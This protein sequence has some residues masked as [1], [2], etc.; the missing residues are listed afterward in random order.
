MKLNRSRKTLYPRALRLLTGVVVILAVLAFTGCTAKP[1]KEDKKGVQLQSIHTN[2][3]TPPSMIGDAV[4]A[5]KAHNGQRYVS[6]REF[7]DIMQY[8][9]DWDERMQTMRIGENDVMFEIRSNSRE[10]RKDGRPVLLSHPAVTI[11]GETFIPADAVGALFDDVMQYKM[12]KEKLL[13]HP[14]GPQGAAN[15]D[16]LPDFADDPGDPARSAAAS[17]E[18]VAPVAPASYDAAAMP[19][20]ELAQ[21]PAIDMDELIR[22]AKQYLGVPYKFGANP[23]SASNKWFD[24]SSYTRHVFAEFGVDLPRLSRS[25]AQEGT[26]VSRT[27]L[28]KGDLLF[29]YLPGRYKSNDI[30]GHVGIYMGNGQM[31]HSSNQPDD[32]VQITSINKEFWKETYLKARRV[33]SSK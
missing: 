21:Q 17:A 26:A 3:G 4:I 13:I 10:A 33:A 20:G 22:T 25:Q 8:Q 29:F 23:Y 12:T 14:T 28:R 7:T 30:V 18:A 1:A 19:T 2:P 27:N 11:H 24:C 16:A 15:P 32:G 5:L 6:L 9:T 31:I